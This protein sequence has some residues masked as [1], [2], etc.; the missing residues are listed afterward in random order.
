MIKT[1]KIYLDGRD[2]LRA[3]VINHRPRCWSILEV[4]E[5]RSA[6]TKTVTSERLA[7]AWLFEKFNGGKFVHAAIAADEP[8]E[9]HCAH[10]GRATLEEST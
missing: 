6:R 9:L 2:V 7:R 1:T 10:C 3:I 5:F 4:T 8:D